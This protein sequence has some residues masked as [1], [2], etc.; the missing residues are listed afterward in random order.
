MFSECTWKSSRNRRS[1]S[2]VVLMLTGTDASRFLAHSQNR[3]SALREG[4]RPQSMQTPLF[5]STTSVLHDR[6]YD[7]EV[8]TINVLER[9]RRYLGA[10]NSSSDNDDDNLDSTEDDPIVAGIRSSWNPPASDLRSS[11]SSHGNLVDVCLGEAETASTEIHPEDANFGV[12][13]HCRYFYHHQLTHSDEQLPRTI[14][15]TSNLK[16]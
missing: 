8:S 5:F 12:G 16:S 3:M 13:M 11:R 2:E 6:D 7:E 10:Y 14:M 4:R 1:H 15:P 9:S